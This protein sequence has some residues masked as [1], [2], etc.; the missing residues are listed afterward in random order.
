MKGV[1]KVLRA[2]LQAILVVGTSALVSY[3]TCEYLLEKYLKE[4]LETNKEFLV[5]VT[6]ITKETVKTILEGKLHD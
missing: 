4:T 5:N 2:L 3:M 1:V 6:K